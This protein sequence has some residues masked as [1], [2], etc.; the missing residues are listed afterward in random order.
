MKIAQV[1]TP[2]TMRMLL[3]VFGSI[4][5]MGCSKEVTELPMDMAKLTTNTWSY[6]RVEGYGNLEEVWANQ[7]VWTTSPL[8]AA[9]KALVYH[10]GYREEGKSVYI[11]GDTLLKS[12]GTGW[13][14]EGEEF[15]INHPSLGKCK[16]TYKFEG[17]NLVYTFV[18][19]NNGIQVETFTRV[20]LGTEIRLRKHLRHTKGDKS[21]ET[22]LYY[23]EDKTPVKIEL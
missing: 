18:S 3:V 23:K 6:D 22:P 13:Q 17:K 2:I 16:G 7:G 8:W 14:K 11:R 15:E 1:P 20:L 5:T 4:L 10:I 9:L 19:K 21:S 12:G